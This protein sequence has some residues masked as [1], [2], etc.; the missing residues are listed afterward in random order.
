MVLDLLEI[1]FEYL[2]LKKIIN[3]TNISS[4]YIVRTTYY[5]NVDTLF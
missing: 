2:F 4:P 5:K 1:I 3:D